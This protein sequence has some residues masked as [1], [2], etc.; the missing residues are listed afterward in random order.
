MQTYVKVNDE[1]H[2]AVVSGKL[3]DADWD[4]RESKEITLTATYAAAADIFKDGISWSIVQEAED[5]T[6]SEEYDNAD[7]SVL[8]DIIVHT[9]GTCTVCMG[10]PTDLEDVLEQLYG[11]IS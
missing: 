5:S 4:G 1:L 3:H 10:K 6:D 2:S 9:D 7:F 8:G 11:G